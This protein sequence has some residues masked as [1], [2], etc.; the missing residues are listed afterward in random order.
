MMNLVLP[1]ARQERWQDGKKVPHTVVHPHTLPLWALGANNTARLVS[2]N[3]VTLGHLPAG[4]PGVV[5]AARRRH[6]RPLTAACLYNPAADQS[7]SEPRPGHLGPGGALGSSP[8]A[9]RTTLRIRLLCSHRDER[10]TAVLEKRARVP[11][12][13]S[14]KEDAL[15]CWAALVCWFVCFGAVA[16]ASSPHVCL[17]A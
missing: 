15:A 16:T 17:V 9:P 11:A 12:K 1:Y 6:H 7:P 5:P 10:G 2:M 8:S 14:L 3:P 13:F 4:E